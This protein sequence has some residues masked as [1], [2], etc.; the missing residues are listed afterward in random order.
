M[1]L[2]GVVVAQHLIPQ[3]QI[4]R[5]QYLGQLAEEEMYIVRVYEMNIKYM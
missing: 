4:E 5:I 3:G 1:L 2:K